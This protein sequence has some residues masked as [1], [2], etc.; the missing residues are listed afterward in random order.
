MNFDS[1]I[2]QVQARIISNVLQSIW[3]SG[4]PVMRVLKENELFL[5]HQY[6]TICNYLTI[7]EDK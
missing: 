1:G 5:L 7:M 6:E 2:I 3:Q 4:Y